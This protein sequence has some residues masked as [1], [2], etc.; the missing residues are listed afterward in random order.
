MYEVGGCSGAWLVTQA[1]PSAACRAESKMANS[2]QS[3]NSA[4][5]SAQSLQECAVMLQ[6][7]NLHARNLRSIIQT[8]QPY[9]FAPPLPALEILCFGCVHDATL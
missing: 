8:A 7:R 9:G 4:P 2:L 6:A 1:P 3:S 5:L